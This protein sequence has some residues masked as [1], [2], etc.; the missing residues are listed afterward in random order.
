MIGHYKQLK[1]LKGATTMNEWDPQ[2]YEAGKYKYFQ[3]YLDLGEKRTLNKVA[4]LTDRSI[5]TIKR[6]SSKWNWVKRAEA[7][8]IYKHKKLHDEYE[9]R[10]EERNR[11]I[12]DMGED[13]LNFLGELFRPLKA[14]IKVWGDKARYC[15]KIYA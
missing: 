13:E 10:W 6:Y 15:N 5:D 14:T 7:Y 1:D 4:D 11:L 12:F 9:Q 2:P 3:T 8:D